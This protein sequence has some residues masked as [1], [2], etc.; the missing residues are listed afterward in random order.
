[1]VKKEKRRGRYK[2]RGE[3]REGD[4]GKS[5]EETEVNVPLGQASWPHFRPTLLC[6][7]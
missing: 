1:M 6:V 3:K 5:E 2:E 7:F 4:M